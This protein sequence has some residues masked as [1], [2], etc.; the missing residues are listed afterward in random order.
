MMAFLC[1]SHCSVY[2]SLKTPF[3]SEST[4]LN[5]LTSFLLGEGTIEMRSK[6]TS[7]AGKS[8][9][10]EIQVVRNEGYQFPAD[11][12]WYTQDGD[13]KYGENYNLNQGG[14]ENSISKV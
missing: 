13:A 8:G 1:P 7:A 11:V 12:E 14:L 3:R 10:A 2:I 4:A 6:T 9:T 5:V